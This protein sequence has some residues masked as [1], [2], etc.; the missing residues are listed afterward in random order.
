MVGFIRR[1]RVHEIGKW[2]RYALQT[3]PYLSQGAPITPKPRAHQ[4]DPWL[5]TYPLCPFCAAPACLSPLLLLFCVAS[6]ARV[7]AFDYHISRN[8]DCDFSD[9]DTQSQGEFGS[10]PK[11]DFGGFAGFRQEAMGLQQ[12]G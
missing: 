8:S 5:T 10:D 4:D 11:E 1:Q 7:D 9:S 6:C 2:C 3:N 12:T